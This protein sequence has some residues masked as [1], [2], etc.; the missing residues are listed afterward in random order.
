[1]AKSETIRLVL[2]TL[3]GML[4]LGSIP[5]LAPRIREL[6]AAQNWVIEEDVFNNGAVVLLFVV[7]VIYVPFVLKSIPN[8]YRKGQFKDKN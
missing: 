2:I 7:F 8:R 3:F 5:F 1:M 4:L 6:L